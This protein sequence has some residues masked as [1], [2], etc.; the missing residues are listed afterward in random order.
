MRIVLDQTSGIDI[1]ALVGRIDGSNSDEVEAALVP[2]ADGGGSVVV[3]CEEL[4]YIS[5][6]GL[7][8]LL[9]AAKRSKAAGTRLALAGL[10]PA[11]GE[12]FEMSGFLKL[13]DIY[14]SRPDAV[15]SLS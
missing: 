10:Q 3:D 6:S 1:V 14:S 9:I 11:V 7:R 2:L 13:F 4:D 8:V 5:S 12:V 15:E